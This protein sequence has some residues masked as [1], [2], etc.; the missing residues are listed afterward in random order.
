MNWHVRFGAF[1]STL[2]LCIALTPAVAQAA[3]VVGSGTP[4]SCQGNALAD[5]LAGGG[6][7]TFN[8]G[9]NP[10]TIIA[11][12]Y[13]IEDDTTIRGENLITLDG[14]NLR[15][16][17][18]VQSGATLTL[19]EIVLL[20][21][22]FS[23]GG[24]IH[25]N[26]GGTLHTLEVTFQS[27]R[28]TG[29]LGGGAVYNEGTFHAA[30]TLFDS[31]HANQEGGAI[32][33]R[34]T[35]YAWFT[36][37]DS[38][39]AGDDSGAIENVLNG[40]VMVNDSVFINNSAAAS[41]GAIGNSLL[42]PT[43]SGFFVVMRS[44]FVDNSASVFGGAINNVIGDLTI[45]NSTFVRNTA[46]Q[47]GA[48]FA[49]GNSDTSIRFSTFVDN[50]ADIGG[51]IF[52]NL[53]AD[54]TLGYS[55]LAASLDEAG[56]SEAL[57]CDG[58]SVTSLGYNLIEDNSC[59]DGSDATD[60]R[61]TPPQL[62]ALGDNGGFS[63]TQMPASS[64]PALAKVPAAQCLSRDQRLAR[65]TGICDIGAAERGGFFDSAFMPFL[66]K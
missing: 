60:I 47:G 31:N 57:E 6:L 55:I 11:D 34:G 48:I 35:L 36:R 30:H 13:V 42:F 44:L 65:R 28:D 49:D 1:V 16:L 50:R 63:E 15:Q 37:F 27:C 22:E 40:V 43:T 2:L 51:A 3:G 61:A 32:L 64:S 56:T 7:V 23:S 58:P 24:C 17:F 62:N 18:I 12:T 14:E 53:T 5:A 21:G 19:E 45:E 41:G 4:A 20:D 39:T 25:V 52:R 9:T 59:V 54:V 66:K 26:S 8:C 38:N 33:N 46:D 29:S 10:T